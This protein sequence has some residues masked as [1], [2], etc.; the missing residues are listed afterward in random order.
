MKLGRNIERDREDVKYLARR[1]YLN[2]ED[3]ERRYQKEMRPYIA[4]PEN[5]TDLTLTFWLE[6][7]REELAANN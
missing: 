4:V 5:S 1:G 6:M 3:L 2:A 7:I